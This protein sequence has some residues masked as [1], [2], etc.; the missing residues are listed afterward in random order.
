[1]VARL[2]L[3][4]SSPGL[5]VIGPDG[6]GLAAGRVGSEP[7]DGA[8]TVGILT[9]GIRTVGTAAVEKAGAVA[10]AGEPCGVARVCSGAEDGEPAGAQAASRLNTRP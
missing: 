8:L 10:A 4:V 3:R 6:W 2:W 7:M 1:M 5:V 9:V